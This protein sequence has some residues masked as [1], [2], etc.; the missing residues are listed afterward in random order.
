MLLFSRLFAGLLLDHIAD[1]LPAGMQILRGG[2][3]NCSTRFAG[4]LAK[5]CKRS[6]FLISCVFSVHES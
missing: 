6:V 5:D 4:T 2:I 1:F 3:H